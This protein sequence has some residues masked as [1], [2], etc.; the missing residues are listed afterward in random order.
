M[1]VAVFCLVQVGAMAFMVAAAFF[2]I[3]RAF[4]K[5]KRLENRLWLRRTV[6]AVYIGIGAA[7]A[8]IGMF[9]FGF[10]VDILRVFWF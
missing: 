7:A 3:A 8:V 9:S 1:G 5:G 4:W 2:F 6:L 10:A